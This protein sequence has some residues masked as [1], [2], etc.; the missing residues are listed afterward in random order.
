MTIRNI[1]NFVFFLAYGFLFTTSFL[2]FSNEESI[3]YDFYQTSKNIILPISWII[4][5]FQPNLFTKKWI[6]VHIL[7][8]FI[9]SY[10]SYIS[11]DSSFLIAY[12]FILTSKFLNIKSLFN[13]LYHISLVCIIAIAIYFLY[14]YYIIDSAEYLYDETNERFR[15]TFEMFYPNVFPMR[16]FIFLS[17]FFIV[18]NKV[19]FMNV[20]FLFVFSLFVY[21]FSYSRTSFLLSSL[22]ISALYINQF[23]TVFRIKFIQMLMT[24]SMLIFPIIS[25]FSMVNYNNF[26]ILE[27]I[28]K[29]LSER[30]RLSYEAYDLLGFALYP[31]DMRMLI[32]EHD[33]I[34][35]NLYVSLSLSNFSL[36]ILFSVASYW[37]I[38]KFFNE[39]FY[40][41]A[42]VFFFMMLYSITESHMIN[43]GYNAM[44]LFMSF[45]FYKDKISN[46]K[47]RARYE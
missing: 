19:K 2:G 8:I 32:Q 40:K 26:E 15:Y 46:Y 37:L 29:V 25:L 9:F 41:E 4:L 10:F 18:K 12:I 11:K 20:I 17:L 14:K 27:Y 34:I 36:L 42:I 1:Y 22:L 35:D 6:L 23:S 43:I 30:I 47:K 44:L 3:F 33:I 28:N 24:L 16:F 5:I 45:L 38:K 39:S 31:R 7:F 21:L 13:M